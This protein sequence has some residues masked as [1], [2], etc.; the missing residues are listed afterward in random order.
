MQPSCAVRVRLGINHAPR[1]RG[2]AI[3]RRAHTRNLALFGGAAAAYHFLIR[4]RILRRGATDQEV[5][6]V[7]STSFR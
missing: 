4:P 7:S 2:A 6:S 3:M 1:S 5:T